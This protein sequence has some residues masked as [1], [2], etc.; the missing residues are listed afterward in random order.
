MESSTTEIGIFRKH[1]AFGVLVPPVMEWCHII[2][3]IG[4]KLGTPIIRWL[5]LNIYIH[6]CPRSLKFWPIPTYWILLNDSCSAFPMSP[7]DGPRW[8]KIRSPMC[9]FGCFFAI[10]GSN[11][12]FAVETRITKTWRMQLH[13][14]YQ[15][16]DKHGVCVCVRYDYQNWL[17]VWNIFYFLMYWE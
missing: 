2:L 4:S 17:V 12:W 8:S 9:F 11:S 15:I 5:I 6:I 1:P 13:F 14:I 3:N 16:A 7:Q 10:P